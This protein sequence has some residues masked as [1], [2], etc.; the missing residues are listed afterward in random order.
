MN[1]HNRK[2]RLIR[3]VREVG[4]AATVARRAQTSRSY[5][6]QIM[7][8]R[9]RRNIGDL[10]ARRLEDAFNKPRGWMD[11]PDTDEENCESFPD[12]GS[13]FSM[14]P[15]LE[16][17]ASLGTGT[18]APEEDNIKGYL[19]FKNVWLQ[20]R[21]LNPRF[22][23]VIDAIGDSM[24]PT[25]NDGDVLLVD[26]RQ[27]EPQD[28]RIFVLRLDNQLYAKRLHTRP[29]QEIEVQSDNPQTPPFPVALGRS[30]GVDIIGR[31]VWAGR[32]M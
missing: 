17:L 24:V 10:L 32:D 25:I 22:L 21:R 27:K 15:R 31:V 29:N 12:F 13:E 20:K 9:G 3:L 4:H 8:S 7:G 14:I 19:A 30:Q 2:E 1:A 16:V 18:A 11:T 5:L 26:L 28:N 6:S 23:T